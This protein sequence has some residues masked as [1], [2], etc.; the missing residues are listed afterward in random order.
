MD[1]VKTA[2]FYSSKFNKDCALGKVAETFSQSS[3][4]GEKVLGQYLK[5]KLDPAV[6][7]QADRVRDEAVEKTAP[8]K[9]KGYEVKNGRK[10]FILAPRPA[11]QA[12]SEPAA[13]SAPAP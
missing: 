10:V 9:V 6:K 1:V 8:Y 13:A 4:E 7:Q 12:A 2:L 11:E 3:D 5:E